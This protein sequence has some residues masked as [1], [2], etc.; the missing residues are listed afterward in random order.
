VSSQIFERGTLLTPELSAILVDSSCAAFS[1]KKSISLAENISKSVSPDSVLGKATSGF[2]GSCWIL[3][4][5]RS[6]MLI[7]GADAEVKVGDF[8]AIVMKFSSSSLRGKMPLTCQK[9]AA[10][11]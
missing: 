3:F 8:W 6:S 9:V 1:V 4:C 2:S 5:K 11:G 7:K 10:E